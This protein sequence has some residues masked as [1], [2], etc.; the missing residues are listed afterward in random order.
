VQESVFRALV[1][2]FN[3]GRNHRDLQHSYRENS[4]IPFPTI[5]IVGLWRAA[6]DRYN[7]N[8]NAC[9]TMTGTGILGIRWINEIKARRNE[10]LH[11]M[12]HQS[13]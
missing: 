7:D 6:Y 5:E 4:N 8:E 10:V 12:K 2:D 3:R 1:H 13:H 11:S 9:R